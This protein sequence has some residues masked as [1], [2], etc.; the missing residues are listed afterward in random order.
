MWLLG[1]SKLH[2]RFTLYLPWVACGSSN[3]FPW[4]LHS[5]GGGKGFTPLFHMGTPYS[6]LQSRL[7]VCS[8]SWGVWVNVT[9]HWELSFHTILGRLGGCFPVRLA[10]IC[11][12]RRAGGLPVEWAPSRPARPDQ[13]TGRG[14]R[15]PLLPVWFLKLDTDLLPAEAWDLWTRAKSH[16][17]LSWV[18][19]LQIADGGTSQPP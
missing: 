7:W 6:S 14:R 8:P 18:A 10:L 5:P 13:N 4:G 15:A 11:G 2:W 9:D 17:W 12:C 19:L 16:H 1:T 3:V